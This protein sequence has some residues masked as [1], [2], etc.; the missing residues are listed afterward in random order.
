M[1]E[2]KAIS[3]KT[4]V[5]RLKY[6][7]VFSEILGKKGKN[8]NSFNHAIISWA[9]NNHVDFEN[10]Y[11]STGE[12]NPRKK[13]KAPQSLANYLDAAKALG[14]INQDKGW[15]FP[16]RYS[17]I[18]KSIIKKESIDSTNKYELSDLEKLFFLY[19]LTSFDTDRFLCVYDLV[20]QYQ[21]LHFKDYQKK[22]KPHYIDFLEEKLLDANELNKQE[23][24]EA[25]NRVRNWKSAIRYSEDIVP[26]RVNWFL[27]LAIIDQMKFEETRTI[28]VK[29]T[30]VEINKLQGEFFFNNSIDLLGISGLT[31]WENENNS[32][33]EELI[34]K[35][36]QLAKNLFGVLNLPR[37]PLE[38]TLLFLSL[39]ILQENF[40]VVETKQL[41]E[42]IGIEKKI[43]RLTIGIRKSGR[44]YESYLYIKNG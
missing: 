16:T 4:Q 34:F 10:Y 31:V 42:W 17:L 22:F 36:L 26:P 3:V 7:S 13:K 12:I 8:I 44:T 6:F 18:L 23:I 19:I 20:L 2:L 32:S 35:F 29:E 30:I 15:L 40:I 11:S 21:G 14:L 27:D 5:R 33:K 38:E 41:E 1:S 37:L 24:L 39:K 9:E 28:V 25:L 43:K